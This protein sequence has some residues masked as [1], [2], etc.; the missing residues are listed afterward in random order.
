MT[1]A[2]LTFSDGVPAV[3]HH[4]HAGYIR[5]GQRVEGIDMYEIE[6]AMSHVEAKIPHAHYQEYMS[7]VESHDQERTR[8]LAQ[9]F[10]I[11]ALIEESLRFQSTSVHAVAL[12][13]GSRALY[14]DLSRDQL[15]EASKRERLEDATALYDRALH[16]SGTTSVL[17]DIPEIDAELWPHSRY[18]PIGRIDPYLY[19]FGHPTYT[20]RGTDTP[21]FRRIF[22]TVLDRQLEIVGLS[23]RPTTLGEYREFVRRALELR[24]ESGFVGL[25]IASAYVRSLAFERV[26]DETADAAWRTLATAGELDP[27]AHKALSDFLT[28]EI[29]EWANDEGVPLQIHSGMGHAEPGL[30]IT[31]ANPLLLE[32]LLG[33]ARLNRL[34]VILIHGGFP[35][36]S[37]LTALAQMYGNVHL[38][39]SWMTY[40]QHHTMTRVL[41]EWL[42]LLPANKV[43][44]GSDT[45]S[46][47]MHYASTMRAR[48][49]LDRVLTSGVRDGLWSVRQAG[50]LAERVMH[51]NLLDVYGIDG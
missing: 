6:N 7:A 47:E 50:W 26:D 39:Y 32:P 8:E 40:L 20:G 19:P 16:L 44:Y 31:G 28:F 10:G 42:E 9:R 46:P 13:E 21:R 35:Y 5:P 43:M 24:R 27:T 14:G 11:P 33:D 37:S 17:T 38:D 12:A 48:A 49:G 3:D 23:Q 25:K 29:A 18:K 2:D 36:S 30:K 4:S 15:I 1:D 51:Q 45:G 34:R 22:S 41:E